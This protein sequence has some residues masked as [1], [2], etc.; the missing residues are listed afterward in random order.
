MLRQV[1]DV[2]GNPF[3]ALLISVALLALGNFMFR[4]LEGRFAQEL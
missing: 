2:I 4:R 1:L 3:V